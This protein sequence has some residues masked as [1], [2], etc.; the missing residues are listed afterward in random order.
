MSHNCKQIF[1][2]PDKLTGNCF[3]VNT[4]QYAVIYL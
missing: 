4:N 1:Y 3:R 2:V